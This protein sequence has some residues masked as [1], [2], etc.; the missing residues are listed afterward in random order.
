VKPAP[1]PHPALATAAE[2][3]GATV[4]ELTV[5]LMLAAAPNLVPLPGPGRR[6]TIESSVRGANLSLSPARARAILG[7]LA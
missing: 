1:P 2:A 3:L 4:G 6:A 5:A 7:A